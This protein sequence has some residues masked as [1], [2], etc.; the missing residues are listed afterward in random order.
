MGL[1][2]SL[3]HKSTPRVGYTRSEFGAIFQIYSQHVYTGLFRDFSFTEFDGRY[4]ISFRE[5][6]G[7]T[8]LITIEKRRGRTGPLPVRRHV[9][10]PKR[11]FDGNRPERK[12]RAF[13]GRPEGKNRN[14]CAASPDNRLISLKTIDFF[15]S[16]FYGLRRVARFSM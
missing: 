5:E 2:T 12:D 15:A 8:P 14:P 6:A 7:A 1:K 11:H 13:R 10:R 16:L 4:Y 3:Q 9:P